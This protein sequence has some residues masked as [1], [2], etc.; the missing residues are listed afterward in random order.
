MK[1]CHLTSAHETEDDR[2]F[3]KECQSLQK[4]GHEV[5]LAGKGDSYSKDGVQIAGVGEIPGN[6]LKRM[7][8]GAR[9][10]YQKALE[11]DCDVYHFHDPELL[12]YGLKLKKKGK[13]V[14]FDSHEDVPATI[15][16]KYWI[17]SP[18]RKAVSS[19][20]RSYETRVVKRLDA[21]V[22]ATPHIAEQFEGR[23]NR[24]EVINNYPKLDDIFFQ[25]KPFEERGPVICYAGGIDESRGE[26][27]MIEAMKEAEGILVLAGDH[28]KTEIENGK[29]KVR[30]VGKLG[31]KEINELYGSARA[32]I[33][34]LLPA[35]NYT[36]AQPIKMYEY[37][38]AGLPVVASSFPLWKK[39]LEE[40]ECGICADPKDPKAVGDACRKL[41]QDPELC[42]RMGLRGRKLVE[43][44]LS[45]SNEEKKLLA[46]YESL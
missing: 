7:T 5:F 11:L 31:R 32:G 45:W 4:A 29:S 26:K 25:T 41:L 12:P 9:L 27:L 3:L 15:R 1:I 35:E 23:A 39:L 20:Y 42:R 40:N 46:L 33:V 2:I 6:R 19:W 44:G 14:I 17:P 24:I 21:V 43:E 10:V 36:E 30:Y 34:V 18:V 8:K 28:E 22:A 13:K 37:M 16:D 38:A